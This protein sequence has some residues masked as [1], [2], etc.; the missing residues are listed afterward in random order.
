MMVSASVKCDPPRK[1]LGRSL[2]AACLLVSVCSS[3]AA[4]PLQTTSSSSETLS[5]RG[6]PSKFASSLTLRSTLISPDDVLSISVYDAP[7]VSGEYASGQLGSLSYR[8]SPE[9]VEA[10]G[11]T[12]RSAL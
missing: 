10:A 8:C 9:A 11:L 2:A 5:G 7:D 12:T 6:L 1:L 4:Q 3:L